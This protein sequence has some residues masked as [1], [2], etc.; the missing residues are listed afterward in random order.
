MLHAEFVP[1]ETPRAAAL[2]VV[3]HGLGD[4]LHGWEWLPGELRLPWMEYALVDA[5][6]P[7]YGGYS[8]YDL[9]GDQGAGIRRSRALLADFIAGRV[10]AGRDPRRIGLLGFSQGCLMAFDVGWRYPQGLGALVGIS[11]YIHEPETLLA[12]LGPGAPSVP[13]L[14]THGRQDPVVPM[15]PVRGQAER[16]KSAGLDL[17]WREFDK[18]HTVAGEAE[19]GLVRGFLARHLGPTPA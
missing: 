2:L 13:A 7:Y 16:L 14:F 17:E 5:P 10:S 19:I 15:I 8:W 4:S 11:G 3:L 9:H 18:P 6:D 12:E 1:A